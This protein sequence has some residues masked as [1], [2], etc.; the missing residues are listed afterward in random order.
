LGDLFLDDDPLV[1][2]DGDFNV[3]DDSPVPEDHPSLRES[4]PR[5]AVCSRVAVA[6][7]RDAGPDLRHQVYEQLLALLSL[8]DAHRQDLRRRGLDDASE[9]LGTNRGWTRAMIVGEPWAVE[10]PLPASV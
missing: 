5:A 3:V 2:V 10:W 8:S 6:D 4:S 7:S 1:E 9:T